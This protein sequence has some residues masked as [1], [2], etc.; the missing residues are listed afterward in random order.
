MSTL[1]TDTLQTTDNAFTFQVSEL[2]NF[3]RLAINTGPDQGASLIG[4]DSTNLYEYLKASVEKLVTNVAAL[5]AVD[6]TVNT[7]VMT[8]GYYTAG[9]GGFAAYYYDPA[10]T[11]TADDGGGVIVA[12][13]GG[14]WKLIN[15][16]LVTV[17]MF[18]ARGDGVTNDTTA[19]T[20]ALA[21]SQKVVVP[22]TSSG[23]LISTV[24]LGT[25]K[26]LQGEGRVKLI[27]GAATAA[28][29]VTGFSL[30]QPTT[31]S[32][33][34]IDMNTAPA[35]S[36]AI[37]FGTSSGVIF[38][39][40]AD[41]LNITNCYEAIGDEV[42]AT[43]YVVDAFFN[44]VTCT[45]SKGRQVYSRRSR[46]FFTFRD[47]RI[48]HTYNLTQVTWEGA[49]FEDFI[50]VELEKFDVVGPTQPTSTYQ[51]SAIG[52]VFAGA[53]G[54]ASIWL[55]RVLV[56]NTRGPGISINSCHNVF[57]IDT[58]VFQNLGTAIELSS[59]LKSEFTNTKVVG[60]LGLTGAAASANGVSLTNCTSVTFTNLAV[61]AC[62]GHGVVHNACTDCNVVG[63]YSNGNTGYGFI[64]ATTAVRNLR[65]NVRAIGNTAG[66]L[67][68]IGAQSTTANWYGNGGTFI[69]ANTGAITV[70]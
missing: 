30:L 57:G 50:G 23:Y 60:G 2:A 62:T 21:Y 43:N 24:T 15:K 25:G 8:S 22:Y 63:G 7:K 39:F 14:R 20:N 19:F 12:T 37:R 27:S 29:R 9:D 46:G 42:H 56:D 17:R 18:G 5:R 34:T 48:D 11:T 13:D 70:P 40:R 52:L 47:F 41:Q 28:I 3:T 32:N 1:R 4:Y 58:C 36:T 66:S 69:A 44:D 68:Q 31:L 45:F 61:E 64:E 67:L 35:G 53:A 38:N 55:R 16:S 33:F 65:S 6:K 51:A 49:R 26:T 59:V 54:S 10:D